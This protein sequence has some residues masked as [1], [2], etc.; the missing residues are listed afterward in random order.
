MYHSPAT[1]AL[2]ASPRAR[3]PR[4]SASATSGN[5]P[6]WRGEHARARVRMHMRVCVCVCVCVSVYAGAIRV[7]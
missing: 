2:V 1:M 6:T 7:Y 4:D 3:W 5:M